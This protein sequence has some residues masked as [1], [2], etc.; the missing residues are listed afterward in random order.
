MLRTLWAA[1][2][3]APGWVLHPGHRPQELSLALVT[4]ALVLLLTGLHGPTVPT[5]LSS[6]L[7]PLAGSSA[8]GGSSFQPVLPTKLDFDLYSLLFKAAQA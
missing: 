5:A 3:A 8:S 2:R 6:T 4:P 7:L 1:C